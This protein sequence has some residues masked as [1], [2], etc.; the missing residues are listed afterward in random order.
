MT[1][2]SR[3]V[4]APS[5]KHRLAEEA[6]G[7]LA[8]GGEASRALAGRT[9]RGEQNTHLARAGENRDPLASELLIGRAERLVDLGL[10]AHGDL[11][12]P[13]LAGGAH[14]V[15]LEP[16]YQ[17]L[18][19]HPVELEGHSGKEKERLAV[20]LEKLP[21]SATVGVVENLRS[22]QNL[23]LLAVVRGELPSHGGE[24]ELDLR[25]RGG[26]RDQGDVEC[27]GRRFAGQVVRGRT[28]SATDQH[29]VAR[30]P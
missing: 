13:G 2:D 22:R 12:R 1:T 26:V 11:D 30:R 16:R 7:A 10:R 14:R 20:A 27:G 15:P 3:V 21:R 29:E 9:D 4:P 28:Q 5:P 8:H 19:G 18:F 23:R 25:E 17:A 6:P 24:T